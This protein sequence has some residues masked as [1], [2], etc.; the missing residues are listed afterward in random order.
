[1]LKTIHWTALNRREFREFILIPGNFRKI[2]AEFPEIHFPAIPDGNGT[3]NRNLPKADSPKP[4]RNRIS[5]P[6]NGENRMLKNR[7]VRREPTENRM[8]EPGRKKA[9]RNRIQ[10]KKPG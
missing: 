5:A 7:Q 9:C 4:E 6:K 2:Q 8:P 3:G 10:P 1:M